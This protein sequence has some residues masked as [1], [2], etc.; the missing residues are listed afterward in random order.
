MAARGSAG[1]VFLFV[2]SA[3]VQPVCQRLKK[4]N[5]SAT[6]AGTAVQRHLGHAG[7]QKLPAR[8]GVAC[9]GGGRGSVAL[10][11]LRL[12]DQCLLASPA[13]DRCPDAAESSW[14]HDR[15]PCWMQCT[16]WIKGRLDP[17]S[18]LF[19]LRSP[20][21]IGHSIEAGRPHLPARLALRNHAEGAAPAGGPD[22]TTAEA[23]ARRSVEVEAKPYVTL[24]GFLMV[25]GH[26][27]D[28]AGLAAAVQPGGPSRPPPDHQPPAMA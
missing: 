11:R 5:C 15:M 17:P 12:E 22:W 7:Q 2:F 1:P 23:A 6:V 21:H 25:G 28:R 3:Q 27:P 4:N 24:Q 10:P 8:D 18:S 14:S 26:V 19:P 13:R 16:V 20:G 9:T